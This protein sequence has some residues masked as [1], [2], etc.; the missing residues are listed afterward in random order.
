MARGIEHLVVL[1][2]CCLTARRR[3]CPTTL[4]EVKLAIKLSEEEGTRVVYI[5][6]GGRAD[7]TLQ[8]RQELAEQTRLELH[9]L[10]P[11]LSDWIQARGLIHEIEQ[12]AELAKLYPNAKRLDLIAPKSLYKR[13]VHL[14]QRIVEHKGFR[15]LYVKI[16]LEFYDVEDRHHHD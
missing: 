4:D 2:P 3:L 16:H 7:H 11:A 13:A 8:E 12:V 9:Q 14:W 10:H 6:T 5:V 15:R 1:F